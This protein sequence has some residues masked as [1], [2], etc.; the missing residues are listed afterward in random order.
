MHEIIDTE[1]GPVLAEWDVPIT[2]D[3]GL[4]LRADVFRPVGDDPVPVL[5]SYGPYG[6]GLHFAEG[7]AS[8]WDA[9]LS[10][11]PDVGEGSSNRFQSW[12]VADPERWV[13]HGYACVRV[14]SR[15]AGRSPGR[16]DSFSARETRDL[17]DCIE[18]AGTQRWSTGKVGLSGISY[19]GM[20][21]WQ[22]AASRP[23]HLAAMCVWEGASDFYREVT[24]HGGILC[25]FT[26][27]WYEMQVVSVQ[28][29]NGRKLLSTI[30]DLYVTGDDALDEST[31]RDNRVDL[32]DTHRRHAFDDAYHAE[33]T[34][35]LSQIDVPL[36]SAGNWGGAGLHLRGNVEGYLGAG[37]DQKW[38]EMHGSEHWT[39]YYTTYGLD[40]QRRFF[41]HFLKGEDNG[42]DRQPPVLLRVRH[43]DGTFS[44][45][46]ATGWPLPDTDWTEL[47]LD[48]AT[49][50]LTDD[51]PAP[52]RVG[53]TER[54]D[55]ATFVLAPSDRT[56]EIT[57][58][59]ALRLFVSSDT[60]DA[61]LFVVVRVFTPD[62]EEIT[63]PGAIDPHSPPAQGWLRTSHRELDP[64]RSTPYRPYHPHTS[65]QPLEPGTTYE[66]EVE[67]WPTSLVLP[68]GYRLAVTVQGHDF[69]YAGAPAALS[70][71]RG[72]L[73]GSGP[74]VHDDPVDRPAHDATRSTAGAGVTLHTGTDTPSRLLVPFIRR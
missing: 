21:Q 71:I 9:L 41:D 53:Y 50:S 3:D 47:F 6:K 30:N 33:R 7:Y 1:T 68:P 58:P 16:I 23:R 43:V 64:E 66:V 40:L 31:L 14:D 54:V 59:L 24:H 20:N 52:A 18:W 13:P 4:V 17:A 10:E 62:G 48:G 34:P 5:L 72:A 35:D 73:R 70:N 69:E 2:V 44:D 65:R 74:F 15:G 25:T 19:Y 39:E 61:D 29:G 60:D 27:H 22:V 42:W 11:H 37:S 51:L 67:I 63:F 12:E 32:G 56:T 46:S 36:L 38:L 49:K 28:H 26:R 57:G 8:A 55:G 45:R